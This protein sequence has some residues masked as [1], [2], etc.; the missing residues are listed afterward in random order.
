MEQHR[1]V[2]CLQLRLEATSV[3]VESSVALEVV[4]GTLRIGGASESEK[5]GVFVRVGAVVWTAVCVRSRKPRFVH[6]NRRTKVDRIEEPVV[7]V[8]GVHA[9]RN[10]RAPNSLNRI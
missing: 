2:D 3:D 9:S 4:C 6:L 10:A 7:A 8:I 1:A 5:R